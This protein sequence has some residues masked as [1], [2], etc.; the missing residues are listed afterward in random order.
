VCVESRKYYFPC[1]NAPYNP[2]SF[3]QAALL[4]SS[5]TLQRVELEPFVHARSPSLSQSLLR[6][7]L[8]HEGVGGESKRTTEED[9]GVEADTG[10]SAVGRGGGRAGLR[11]ALGLWVTLLLV[12]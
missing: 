5:I 9:N 1:A 6:G 2:R 10:R 8:V 4:V 12:R 7:L 11:V 3:F